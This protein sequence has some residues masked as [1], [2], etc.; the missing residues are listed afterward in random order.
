M[1][2]KY[3]QTTTYRINTQNNKNTCFY[4]YMRLE[5]QCVLFWVDYLQDQKHL[6]FAPS[7]CLPRK[8]SQDK[9]SGDRTFHHLQAFFHFTTPIFMLLLLLEE[10]G[11]VCMF[12]AGKM[13]CESL[14]KHMVPSDSRD[15]PKLLQ[16]TNSSKTRNCAGKP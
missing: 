8:T 15:A 12:F 2:K 13:P 10:H 6:I 5:I 11:R 16:F 1:F 9:P 3:L 7:I 4:I 14:G